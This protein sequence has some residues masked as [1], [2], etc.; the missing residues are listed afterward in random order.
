MRYSP[1]PITP[2]R[3]LALPSLPAPRGRYRA[4][5]RPSVLNDPRPSRPGRR[6]P[7]YGRSSHVAKDILAPSRSPRAAGPGC[8]K[9]RKS[10]VAAA[11]GTDEPGRGRSEAARAARPRRQGERGRLAGSAQAAGGKLVCGRHGGWQMDGERR[12]GWDGLPESVLFRVQAVGED[13]S[14]PR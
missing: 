10:R 6:C 1:I 12:K 2:H 4:R 14:P 3:L 8:S 7:R 11:A 9:A 5:H 13:F